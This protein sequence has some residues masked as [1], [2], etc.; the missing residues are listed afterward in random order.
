MLANT[1]TW[2]RLECTGSVEQVT[3]AVYL[4]LIAVMPALVGI[5][6]K[7]NSRANG[8]I[9]RMKI[10]E[11]SDMKPDAASSPSDESMNNVQAALMAKYILTKPL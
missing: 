4:L 3:V 2:D 7:I 6:E 5:K 11:T 10:R 8:I 9:C 1:P